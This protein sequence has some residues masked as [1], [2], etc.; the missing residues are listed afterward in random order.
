MFRSW[1]TVEPE[2]LFVKSASFSAFEQQTMRQGRGFGIELQIEQ[3]T[4][5]IVGQLDKGI[6]EPLDEPKAYRLPRCL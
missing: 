5:R 4:L 6:A 2:S 1:L 3:L